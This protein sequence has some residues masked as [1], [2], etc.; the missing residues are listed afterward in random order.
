MANRRGNPNW[1]KPLLH[2]SSSSS[3]SEFEKQVRQLKLT[4]R[5]CAASDQLRLWCEENKNRVYIPESLLK[6]WGISVNPYVSD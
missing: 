5:D 2:S 6:H 3:E 1:G 4:E